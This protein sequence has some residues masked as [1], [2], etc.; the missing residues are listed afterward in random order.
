MPLV[1]WCYKN[2]VWSWLWAC[3]WVC[4]NLGGTLIPWLHLTTVQTLAPNDV[5]FTRWFGRTSVF[6]YSLWA[7]YIE[8]SPAPYY[9]YTVYIYIYITLFIENYYEYLPLKRVSPN[10]IHKQ[11]KTV[12]CLL[13]MV[14]VYEALL[15]QKFFSN[16]AVFCWST[17]CEKLE[18]IVKSVLENLSSSNKIPNHMDY[19]NDCIEC[20]TDYAF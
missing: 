4:R 14:S 11:H 13:V 12:H 9:I 15:T 17:S 10:H 20:C 6:F 16:Q 19:W 7:K 5:I 1:I 8:G 18:P 2:G 3:D